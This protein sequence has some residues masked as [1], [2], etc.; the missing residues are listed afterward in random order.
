MQTSTRSGSGCLG[1]LAATTLLALT[2]CVDV[3]QT[4]SLKPDG[5]GL[6]KVR[7]GMRADELKR[8]EELSKMA[9]EIEGITPEEA[10]DSPFDFNEEDIRNDFAE[11]RPEDVK[12]E[13]VQI[14]ETNG[15]KYVN[16]DI[17]FKRLEGLLKTDF[18]SDESITLTR[19]GTDT[20]TFRHAPPVEKASETKLEGMDAGAIND[21]MAGMMKG[22]RAV[23]RVEVPGTVQETN[24]DTHDTTSATWSYDLEKDTNALRRAQTQEMTLTFSGKDLHLPELAPQ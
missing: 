19:S 21:L 20:Y 5:S 11:Y 6:F 1:V 23:L 22:F 8:M 7:Y 2:G 13:A 9:A 18:V 16:L 4:L 12:L 10:S 14:T 24:A 17:S 3:E 15:W